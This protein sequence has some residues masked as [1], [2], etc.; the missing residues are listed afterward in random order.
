MSD[1]DERKKR[2][3]ALVDAAVQSLGEHFDTVQVLVTRESDD[4]EKDTVSIARGAGNWYARQ[5][6]ML[7]W[8]ERGLEITRDDARSKNDE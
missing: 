5:G 6:Q 7:H 4:G 2:E 8:L 3:Q 1:S